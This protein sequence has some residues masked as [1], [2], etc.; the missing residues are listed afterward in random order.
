MI[1]LMVHQLLQ[2][3][4]KREQ[5]A[6]DTL[7]KDVKERVKKSTSKTAYLNDYAALHSDHLWNHQQEWLHAKSQ[8]KQG[9]TINQKK[10]KCVEICNFAPSGFPLQYARTG[11]WNM[12]GSNC[13]SEYKCDLFYCIVTV[14]HFQFLQW[15]LMV[16][17]IIR[18]F[19]YFW[20][21]LFGAS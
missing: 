18:Q 8:K 19:H 7:T 20:Q 10:P 1:S 17:S 11:S 14:I 2:K 9:K 16:A 13:S 3:E 12:S 4:T 15:S 21:K 6:F 5:L